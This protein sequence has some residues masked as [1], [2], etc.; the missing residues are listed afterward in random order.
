LSG[1][2]YWSVVEVGGV[3]ENVLIKKTTKGR[4]CQSPGIS[5]FPFGL[6]VGTAYLEHLPL[7]HRLLSECSIEVL[8]MLN[9]Q[10]FLEPLL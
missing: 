4:E 2:F 1:L 9:L 10:N 6:D 7:L 5:I 8:F 3:Q